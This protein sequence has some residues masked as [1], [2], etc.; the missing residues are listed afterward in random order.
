MKSVSKGTVDFKNK[1][2]KI[3]RSIR[4]KYSLKSIQYWIFDDQSYWALYN[5][6][7]R[8]KMVRDHEKKEEIY[9]TWVL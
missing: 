2:M 1:Q 5:K 6:P 7:D 8:S 9:H 3:E 4:K